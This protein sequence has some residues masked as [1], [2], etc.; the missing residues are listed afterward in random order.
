MLGESA[1]ACVSA[2]PAADVILLGE[3]H[4]LITHHVLE[5]MAVEH[6][7]GQRRLTALVMEMADAGHDTTDLQPDANEETVRQRLQWSDAGWPWRDYGPVV[8][9]AVKAGIPVVGGNLPRSAN[10]AVMKDASLDVLLE[11]DSR[12]ELGQVIAQ[13]HCGLLPE[14]QVP[15]MVRIQIARDRQMAKVVTQWVRPG[16]T[17]LLVAGNEHARKDRGVPLYLSAQGVRDVAVVSMQRRGA[18]S[19]LS[20]PSDTQWLT[21]DKP[22]TTDHCA[23]LRQQFKKR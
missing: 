1:Q 17:A 18:E 20:I 5:Q 23:E 6:L 3:E 13:A 7:V 9:A 16:K 4:D 10:A 8:M 21:P 19:P 14:S 15:G 2:L 22:D 11:A 12:A